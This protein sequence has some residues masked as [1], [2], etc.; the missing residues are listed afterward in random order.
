MNEKIQSVDVEAIMAEIQEKIKE[1]GYSEDMLSF[2]EIHVDREIADGVSGNSVYYSANEMNRFLQLAASSH[3]IPYYEPFQ[4]SKIK[5][6]IKRVM[7]KLMAFQMQPLRDRQNYFN[8]QILQSVRML[9]AHV[10]ELENVVIKKEMMIEEL[11]EKI[12]VL[13]NK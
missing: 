1:R 5:I 13:E 10:A 9:E 11:E 6:F 8:Y 3:N 2:N 7:R 4:G 12:K